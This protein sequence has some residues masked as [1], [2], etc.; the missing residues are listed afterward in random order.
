MQDEEIREL[1]QNVEALEGKN[2]ALQNDLK[3]AREA[4]KSHQDACNK[5]CGAASPSQ[6]DIRDLTWMT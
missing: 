1:C 2:V 4:I 3:K 6:L 5:L